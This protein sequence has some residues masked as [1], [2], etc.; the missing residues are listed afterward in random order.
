MIAKIVT[1]LYSH[2]EKRFGVTF[3]QFTFL[4]VVGFGSYFAGLVTM[5]ALFLR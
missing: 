1:Y 3:E 5:S 2:V 4:L